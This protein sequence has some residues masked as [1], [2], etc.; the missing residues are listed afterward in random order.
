MLNDLSVLDPESRAVAVEAL[1]RRYVIPEITRIVASRVQFGNF[2]WTVETNRGPRWFAIQSPRRN[3][4]W[5][6][7]DR[8][9][10]RDSLNVRYEIPSVKALDARSR[11]EIAQIS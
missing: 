7:H 2:Y 8:V 11:D 1:E 9:M 4:T 10:I 3:M 6:T 5:I